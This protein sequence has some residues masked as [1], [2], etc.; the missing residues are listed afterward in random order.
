MR[1]GA[2]TVP[3]QPKVKKSDVVNI[4]KLGREKALLEENE[5]GRNFYF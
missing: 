2:M 5:V 4:R 1:E 3:I